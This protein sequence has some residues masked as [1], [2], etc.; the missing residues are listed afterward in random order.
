MIGWAHPNSGRVRLTSLGD[1]G[2]TEL[3]GAN[4]GPTD[5]A[6]PEVFQALATL[7]SG[8]TSRQVLERVV[9]TGR[10][11]V[12]ARFGALG[13]AGP[14]NQLVEFIH[15]GMDQRAAGLIGRAPKGLGLLGELLTSTSP[16]RLDDVA[17]RSAGMAIPA[18]HP[19]IHSF[20]GVPIRAGDEPI[21]S[22]YLANKRGGPFTVADEQIV[23]ALAGVAAA[24]VI[25]ARAV[26]SSRRQQHAVEALHGM[27][28][29]LLAGAAVDEVLHLMAVHAKE[30]V[31]ADMTSVTVTDRRRQRLT[32]R[33][34]AG[35]LR[36]TLLNT[37]FADAGTVQGRVVRT[38]KTAVLA[39]VAGG[40][41]TV[42]PLGDA[43]PLGPWMSIPL[44]AAG[45]PFGVLSLG[46]VRGREPFDAAD[47]SLV[48][49]FGAQASV[50]IR[51]GQAHQR[52]AVVADTLRAGLQPRELPAVAGVDLAAHYRPHSDE[53]GGDLYDVFPLPSSSRDGTEWGFA[54]GDVTGSG[55]Q[56]ATYTSLIRH[57][58]QTAAMLDADPVRVMRLLNRRL[59]N[60]ADEHRFSTAVFGR[61]A[62]TSS[63][64]EVCLVRAGHPYPL[65]VR[66]DGS[67][68]VLKP[69]GPLLGISDDPRFGTVN[70]RLTFG[71]ALVLYTDGVTEARAGQE[72]FGLERLINTV[73]A[74]AGRPAESLVAVID[75]AVRA[76]ADSPI[77][78]LAI[79]V[80]AAEHRVYH[81]ARAPVNMSAPQ[82]QEAA[83]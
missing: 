36:A 66:S 19:P 7:H 48:E 2:R 73:R 28:S 31:G 21:G 74:A 20:L 29:A 52:V 5:A 59:M 33:A 60:S 30:L 24:A 38:G 3:R 6:L 43:M 68:E 25:N 8:L 77:D 11:L 13:V 76:F 72:Q 62:C 39:D 14:D 15:E 47:K 57:T 55:P 70:V 1:D 61:L 37:S 17:A 40:A 56:A 18:G 32:V 35:D 58:L 4:T 51:Y 82:L 81:L 45:R 67:V 26:E 41:E 50:A 27:S 16:I 69:P 80:L 65:V 54:I 83:G 9:Q 53:V 64:L 42:G 49:A 63:A 10:R 44:Q 79:V 75:D 23:Q 46:R 34:F 12:K 22:L 71:D 78:D